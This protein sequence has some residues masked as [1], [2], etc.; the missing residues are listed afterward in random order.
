[1][2]VD[3]ITQAALEED[4][5]PWRVLIYAEYEGDVLRATSGLYPRTITGSGDAE[6]NGTY[7]PY[8][9]NLVSVS[10]VTHQDEG[11]DTVTIALS[12]LIVNDADFL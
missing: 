11:S 5:T 12:G 4:V 6:L 10:D 8:D 2:A 3:A 7:T 1:M 9:H